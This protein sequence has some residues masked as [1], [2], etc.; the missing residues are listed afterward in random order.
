MPE[1]QGT[2]SKG[3]VD[4]ESGAAHRACISTK[5]KALRPV[6]TRP[7]RHGEVAAAPV[8]VRGTSESTLS[9]A[10]SLCDWHWQPEWLSA[11]PSFFFKGGRQ[12]QSGVLAYSRRTLARLW[13]GLLWPALS[14]SRLS[15]L[16]SEH[17]VANGV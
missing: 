16:S 2:I 17:L 15:R 9:G 10:L 13:T 4:P 3:A 7:R 12:L 8:P 11:P 6:S 1:R 5:A 14:S